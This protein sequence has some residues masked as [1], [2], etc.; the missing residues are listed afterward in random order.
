MVIALN[1][2]PIYSI[3]PVSAKT[4]LAPDSMVLPWPY[5]LVMLAS[6]CVIP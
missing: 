6:M 1:T 2:T 4:K 5:D 3:V